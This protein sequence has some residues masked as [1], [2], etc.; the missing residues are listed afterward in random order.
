MRI[1]MLLGRG[2]SSTILANAVRTWHPNAEFFLVLE[3]PP[4]KRAMLRHRRRRLGVAV[5]CGQLFFQ[6][7]IVPLI[8]FSSTKRINQIM[9]EYNLDASVESLKDALEVTS[10]N[11]PS[12]SNQL[13]QFA[14]DIVLVNGTRIIKPDV[15]SCV[16][17][18]FINTHVGI[19][20][21]YR[22]VHGGY[23]ALWND[24]PDNF[25][26][27]IHLVDAGVDTG[28]PLRQVR[29]RPSRDDTFVTYPLLQ[30]AKALDA[31]RG[32]LSNLPHSLGMKEKSAANEFS[33]Q[34]FHPTVSQYLRG[35]LRGVR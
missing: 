27:T 16:K 10:V 7:M 1:A 20:P 25:G 12:V 18:D 14:P 23:W 6:L 3:R 35:R 33:R 21:M 28:H 8:R 4:S 17:A 31:I 11:E 32:I 26:V 24:D 9:A 30:Q 34:W 29:V 19:T 15:L 22:G 5:V 13:A 2:S